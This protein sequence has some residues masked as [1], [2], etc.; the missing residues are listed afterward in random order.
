MNRAVAPLVPAE[1]ALV[2]DTTGLGIETVLELA[3]KHIVDK[4]SDVSL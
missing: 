2:I 1:D 4:L 3:L